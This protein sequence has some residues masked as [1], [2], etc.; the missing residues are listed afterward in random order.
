[1]LVKV[2]G[3]ELLKKSVGEETAPTGWMDVVVDLTP[4]A[5]KSVKLEL[6][7]QASGWNGAFAYWQG[8]SINRG[9]NL[10][11]AGKES[12]SRQG[13]RKGSINDGDFATFVV[14]YGGK[15][16]EED[17]FA[18]SLDEMVTVSSVVF[19]H[20]QNFPDGGWFDA[21]AGKPR[22]QVQV[23]KGGAWETVGELSDYPKT[24]AEKKWR[25]DGGTGVH[26][27][28]GETRKGHR[29][30]RHRQAGQRRQSGPGVLFV[31]RT[32]GVLAIC[33]HECV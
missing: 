30:A 6:W 29:G 28:I 15:L 31:F 11:K 9:V 13:N 18:V 4:Y 7:N 8:I 32:A 25:A 17:W 20:G 22:V 1:M 21:S 26:L 12:R 33:L 23:S 10:L 27:R 24:T 19:G 14:T 3:K 5:G 2:D 16:V